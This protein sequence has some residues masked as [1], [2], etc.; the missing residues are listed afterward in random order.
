MSPARLSHCSEGGRLAA[1]HPAPFVLPT[2]QH[3]RGPS[4]DDRGATCNLHLP[5]TGTMQ[6]NHR[7][8]GHGSGQSVGRACCCVCTPRAL[9]LGAPAFPLRRSRRFRGGR[10]TNW[11][12]NKLLNCRNSHKYCSTQGWLLDQHNLLRKYS[13]IV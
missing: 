6:R 11:G 3:T 13:R 5:R 2:V 8:S 1:P 9:G 7:P 4:R 12:E 10:G